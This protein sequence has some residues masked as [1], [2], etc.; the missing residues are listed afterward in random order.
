[1]SDMFDALISDQPVDTA[2]LANRLRKKEALGTLAALTGIS[3]LQ[4]L[5]PQM[6]EDAGK[7]AQ[8]YATLR[9][10]SQNQ[11]L[12]RALQMQGQQ[13]SSQDR[14]DAIAQRREASQQHTALMQALAA[15]KAA[16]SP[17]AD[18]LA[19][20]AVHDAVVDVMADPARMRQ[21]AS[22]G[23]SGQTNRTL[24]NNEKAKTLKD[25]GMTE[26]DVIRQQAVAKGQIKSVS[27][28]IPM[29]NAVQAYEEVARGNGS[30]VLEL[31]SKVNKSGIPLI[32]SAMRLGEQATGNPDA[33][34]LMQVLQNYQ[35]EV[36]RIIA[37]PRLTGQLTDTARKEIEHVVPANLTGAQAERIVK[38][39]NFEFDLRTRGLDK[40]I[41]SAQGQM[42]PGYN[43]QP[44]TPPPGATPAAPAMS[45]AERAKA[46][47]L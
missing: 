20:D 18:S 11:M 36:A 35:T 42:T 38:R 5:G 33:A 41:E 8:D 21:Y 27:D 31:V 9:D 14:Q 29:K 44:P 17:A 32:N 16:N 47:G 23:Q 22:F 7:G 12:Q 6:V 19:P 34:E 2:D 43:P 4:K 10:R 3:G 15:Q 1:M 45:A 37:N 39:L 25:I 30:R 46:L 13:L 28:L 26:Q 40:A 24:I